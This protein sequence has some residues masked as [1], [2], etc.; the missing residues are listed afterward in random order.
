MYG[1]LIQ[2][3]EATVSAPLLILKG[4]YEKR[5]NQNPERYS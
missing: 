5:T 1:N 2:K 3:Y 4:F